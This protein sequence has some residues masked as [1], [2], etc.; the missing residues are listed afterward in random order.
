MSVSAEPSSTATFPERKKTRFEGFRLGRLVFGNPVVGAFPTVVPVPGWPPAPPG[1][2]LVPVPPPPR[3]AA[4]PT[5]RPITL[6][7]M[8]AGRNGDFMATPHWLTV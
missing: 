2:P 4:T 8:R 6:S 3:C 1:A 5:D 7:T